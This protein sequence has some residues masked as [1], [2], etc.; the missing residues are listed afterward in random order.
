MCG[1]VYESGGVIRYYS[2]GE[3]VAG[4]GYET[5]AIYVSGGGG[6]EAARV[7]CLLGGCDFN[8]TV[9][10]RGRGNVLELYLSIGD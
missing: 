7:G 9:K 1:V 6:S 4:L 8:A 10:C 5:F 2:V 3:R